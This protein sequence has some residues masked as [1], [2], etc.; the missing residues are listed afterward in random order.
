MYSNLQ[1]TNSPVAIHAASPTDGSRVVS[2]FLQGQGPRLHLAQTTFPVQWRLDK[3]AVTICFHQVVD[4]E[5]V[6]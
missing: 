1:L 4:L 3:A 5:F 2:R 6:V